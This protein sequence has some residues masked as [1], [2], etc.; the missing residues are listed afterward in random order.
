LQGGSWGLMTNHGGMEEQGK[1]KRNINE[2]EKMR[3]DNGMTSQ[4]G[5]MGKNADR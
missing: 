2:M 1:W 5:T 4:G 3:D